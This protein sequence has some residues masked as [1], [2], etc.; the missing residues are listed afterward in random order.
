MAGYKRLD[1]QYAKYNLQH[2]L[3]FAIYM[4][5]IQILDQIMTLVESIKISIRKGRK[6]K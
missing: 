1:K 5:I 2:G 6:F 3:S 4:P